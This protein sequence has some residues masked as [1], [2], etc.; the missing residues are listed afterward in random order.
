MAPRRHAETGR[1]QP[2][3]RQA[4]SQRTKPVT[5]AG[6]PR[7]GDVKGPDGV[8][9]GQQTNADQ[10][11]TGADDLPPGKGGQSDDNGGTT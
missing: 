1:F 4:G 6:R 10:R 3:I 2:P 5:T 8:H 11:W 9:G 7:I